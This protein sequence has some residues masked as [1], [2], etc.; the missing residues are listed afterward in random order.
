MK[1]T[2]KQSIEVIMVYSLYVDLGLSLDWFLSCG[3][4]DITSQ[5]ILHTSN[6][7]SSAMF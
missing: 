1:K 2:L 3:M 4:K 7:R 5:C 6:F